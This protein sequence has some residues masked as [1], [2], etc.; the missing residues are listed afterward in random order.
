VVWVGLTGSERARMLEARRGLALDGLARR[1]RPPG[2]PARAADDGASCAP[3]NL[4]ARRAAQAGLLLYPRLAGDG[5]WPYG[6]AGC[7][8][9]WGTSATVVRDGCYQSG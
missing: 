6:A 5:W 9:L 2:S 1:R 8:A 7:R 3:I 4:S